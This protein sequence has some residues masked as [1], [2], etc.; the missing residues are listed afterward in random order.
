M[1]SH[2][3]PTGRHA[4]IIVGH[5]ILETVLSFQRGVLASFPQLLRLLVSRGGFVSTHG[6]LECG[7]DGFGKTLDVG[8]GG[9]FL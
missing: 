7:G 5:L 1:H 6:L 3:L 9:G 2:R 8:A 4:I